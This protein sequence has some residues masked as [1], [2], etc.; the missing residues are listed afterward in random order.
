MK[1]F[2]FPPKEH[3]EELYYIKKLN[4]H[5]IAEIYCIDP[6]T[7]H[8]CFKFYDIASRSQSDIKKRIRLNENVIRFLYEKIGYTT[9]DLAKK[10]NVSK[11]YI[12]LFMKEFGIK[13]DK[14]RGSKS[15][16]GRV[17]S[18]EWNEKISNSHKKKGLNHHMCGEKHPQFK[19]PEK[20]A[21]KRCKGGF[22]KDLGIYVRSTWEA[23]Y[24][25]Y[26]NF[27]VNQNQ[28]KYWEYEPKT[29]YF[30]KIKRGSRSYTPDFRITNIDGSHYW[31]EVKGYMNSES[32]TKIKR[33]KKY[34]P[35]EKFI[36]VDKEWFKANKK[37]RLLIPD[38]EI[39]ES[40]LPKFKSQA[41]KDEKEKS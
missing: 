6:N 2:I 11:G 28:I 41:K 4:K 26:L 23:N 37:M 5:Q 18:K 30:E 20:Y 40:S 25:R 7:L 21:N 12:Y 39:G 36:L 1:K 32:A 13:S 17:H 19:Y 29:F 8:K 35:E 38:W 10:F 24:S 9:T 16:I 15:N 33:F 34:F 22:R 3:I 14:T 31:V 27:L